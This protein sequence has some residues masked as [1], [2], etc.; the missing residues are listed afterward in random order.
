MN[1]LYVSS[2]FRKFLHDSDNP[3]AQFIMRGIYYQ[4]WGYNAHRLMIRTDEVNYLTLRDDGTISYLPKGKEHKLTDDGRW[5]RDGRQNGTAGKIIKKVLKPHAIKL[6]KEIEFTNF[7]NQY[8]AACDAE[9]K[10]FVIRPNK[11][12]P[13]VYCMTREHGGAGLNESCMNGDEDYL[14]MYAH[15]PHL[16][17]L[18]MINNEGHLA[19]R[20]LLWNTE[21][22]VLM[23][24][25]YVAKDHYYDMFLE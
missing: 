24:R 16:R 22:G 14:Q 21:D 20:A 17:I 11:D 25:V 18:T 7:V 12:I 1:N 6:F 15:C 4:G 9:C 10:Q 8:K 19:G 5:A 2:S 23:D 13:D 3:V